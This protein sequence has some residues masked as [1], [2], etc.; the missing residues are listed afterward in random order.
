MR[1][2]FDRVL[3]SRA[4]LCCGVAAGKARDFRILPNYVYGILNFFLYFFHFSDCLKY[5][6]T[7]NRFFYHTYIRIKSQVSTFYSIFHPFSLFFGK[8]FMYIFQ[9]VFLI[10]VNS[11][12]ESK[13][14]M[15][16]KSQ[17]SLF[18]YFSPVFCPF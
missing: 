15:H 13:I 6:A 10:V 12:R 16:K 8:Y 11:D 18:C 4:F 9:M 1:K 17:V 2:S 14:P 3:K 5:I 7:L